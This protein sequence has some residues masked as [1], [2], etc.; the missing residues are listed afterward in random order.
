MIKSFAVAALMSGLV[1]SAAIAQTASPAPEAPAIAP[2]QVAPAQVRT[3][4]QMPAPAATPVATP[5]AAGAA[6]ESPDQCLK[7]A[8]DLAQSAEDRKLA[9]AQLDKI[10]DLLTKMETHCDAKQFV[11][12][13]SVANDIKTLIETR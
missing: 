3:P 11:E 2:V 8:S 10:E 1:A 12:A 7:A 4:G 9:E 5:Q 6:P 13:M